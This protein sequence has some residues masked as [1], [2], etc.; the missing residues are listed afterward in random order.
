MGARAKVPDY[1]GAVL[2]YQRSVKYANHSCRNRPARTRPVAVAAVLLVIG[3]LGGNLFFRSTLRYHIPHSPA[4]PEF[5][6][7]TGLQPDSRRTSNFPP[8]SAKQQR[9]PF[10]P[11]VPTTSVGSNPLVAASDITSLSGHWDS[12]QIH[13]RDSLSKIF[14]RRGLPLDDLASMLADPRARRSLAELRVGAS[15]SFLRD[16]QKLDG[17]SYP[18]DDF[19][20]LKAVRKDDRFLVSIESIT[21]E[22]KVATAAGSISR[23]LFT[24]LLEAGVPERLIMQFADLF[25]WD[26][27][28][29]RDIKRGDKFKIVFEEIFRNGEKMGT[30]KILAAEFFND[31]KRHRAFYFSGANGADGY[32]N[33]F[34]EAMKKAFLLAPLNFTKVSSRFNLGRMHPILNR[35]RAHKGVDYAAPMGTPVRAVANGRIDFAGV[36]NGYGNVLVLKHGDRYSTLYGHMMK[37]AAGI[38][39]GDAVKQGQLIGYVGKTG[40]ATG[41]HLHYEFRVDGVHVDPLTAKLPQA[42]PLEKKYLAEFLKRVAPAV[43]QLDGIATDSGTHRETAV[44]KNDSSPASIAN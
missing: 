18:I 40:L 23:S 35:I 7:R 3:L 17:L 41:P 39:R 22:L 42:I 10:E 19:N 30:G 33:Q 32:Y 15:V 9:L 27:D 26:V 6:E 11:K 13:P 14:S 38:S 5:Q 29:V 28:F 4:L 44:S 36:Q 2:R 24:D 1:L 25:G 8:L 20:T 43:S 34:G 21:P 12:E 16:R 37:F 31:G